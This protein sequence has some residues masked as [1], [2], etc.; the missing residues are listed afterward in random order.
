MYGEVGQERFDLGF[1]GE[2]VLTG[3]ACCGNEQTA[4]SSLRRIARCEW[5]SGVDGAPV[6]LDRGVL[7]VDFLSSQAYKTP[8][9]IP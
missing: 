8:I 3:T 2:E 9:M 6:G 4:R 5:S 7:V 1:G